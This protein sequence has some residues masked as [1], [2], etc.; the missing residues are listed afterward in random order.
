[1][2]EEPLSEVGITPD[3]VF[4]SN[5]QL[6]V[7]DL[8]T[9]LNVSAYQ[10]P[11]RLAGTERSYQF[12]RYIHDVGLKFQEPV[13]RFIKLVVPFFPTVRVKHDEFHPTP[14]A[15]AAWKAQ[16]QAKEEHMERIVRGMVLP[17]RREEGC[18]A[19]GPSHP[20]PMFTFCWE[21]HGNPELVSLYYTRKEEGQ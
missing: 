11:Q 6:T 14:A 9:H 19:Y 10:L 8:K 16:A 1:M 7:V 18:L 20:C 5:G 2:V 13:D 15:L 4:R 21:C 3:G 17:Y 12:W